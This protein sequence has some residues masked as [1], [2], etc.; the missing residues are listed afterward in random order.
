MRIAIVTTDNRD[1]MKD[2]KAVTPLFGPAP[3]ALLQGFALLPE[4]EVHVIV[5]AREPMRCP[6]KIAPNMFFHCLLVP[7]IG[8]MRTLF[9]GCIRAVRGKLKETPAGDRSWSG[10]GGALCPFGCVFRLS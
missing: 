9:Q 4:V 3:E 10:H 6:E 5:C 2:Y 7:K 1:Q 8:W